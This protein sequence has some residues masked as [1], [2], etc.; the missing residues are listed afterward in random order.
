MIL[1][2]G[3]KLISDSQLI[4]DNCRHEALILLA[5]LHFDKHLNLSCIVCEKN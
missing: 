1:D 2:G 4:D 5:S 3:E